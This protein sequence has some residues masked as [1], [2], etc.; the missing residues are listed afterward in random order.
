MGSTSTFEIKF[1]IENPP[2]T[3]FGAP[4]SGD[5]IDASLERGRYSINPVSSE[6]NEL[7]YKRWIGLCEVSPNMRKTIPS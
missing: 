5:L 4:T 1:K 7:F 3:R 6:L 2:H